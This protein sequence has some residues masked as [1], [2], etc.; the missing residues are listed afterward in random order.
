MNTDEHGYR[1][2]AMISAGVSPCEGS[3]AGNGRGD[4][5]GRPH[6]GICQEDMPGGHV[7][8]ALLALR[9]R[10]R[11][12]FIKKQPVEK[13]TC[14]RNNGSTGGYFRKQGRLRRHKAAVAATHVLLAYPPSGRPQGSPLCLR[15]PPPSGMLKT[16]AKYYGAE[17][18]FLRQNVFSYKT[19]TFASSKDIHIIIYIL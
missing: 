5:C 7:L 3:R 12:C 13:N 2:A 18:F 17:Y 9:R 4:P 11:P 1:L 6:T 8:R 19:T 15:C 14:L 10:R 16:R